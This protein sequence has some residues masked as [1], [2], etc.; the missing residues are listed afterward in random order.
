MFTVT[1]RLAFPWESEKVETNDRKKG[2]V[3]KNRVKETVKIN[4]MLWW[5]EHNKTLERE[6]N[7]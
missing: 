7:H 1:S 3:E 4:E 6:N 2:K 5:D